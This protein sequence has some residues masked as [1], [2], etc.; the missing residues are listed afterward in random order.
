MLE[1]KPIIKNL[2]WILSFLCVLF[3]GTLVFLSLFTRHKQDYILPDFSNLSVEEALE[4]AKPLQLRLEVTDS[5]YIPESPK[6]V[7][8]RQVPPAGQHVKK[9]RRIELTINS[10]TPR[11]VTMPSLVGFS[12]R[13]AKAVLSSH[14]LQLGKLTYRPDLA[15][16]NVL[17]QRYKGRT[18]AAGRQIDVF[19]I[20]DLE[21]GVDAEHSLAYVPF[22]TG[23]NLDAAKDILTDHSLNVGIVRYDSSV[24]TA[25]DTL[26]ARVFQQIPSYSSV[27]EWPLGTDVNITLTIDPSLLIVEEILPKEESSETETL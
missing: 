17:A 23:K 24:Q 2:I 13:Q 19:S 14:G 11:Q 15:T 7:I 10:L 21:L 20:I 4:V 3:I 22:L 8:F 12:L 1:G 18:V 27:P 16:N 25:A 6:G 9:N 5:L 26:A